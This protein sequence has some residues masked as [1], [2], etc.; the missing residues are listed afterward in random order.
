MR[1]PA[2]FSDTDSLGVA[3][4]WLREQIRDEGARCPC[5]TQMAKVYPRP[6]YTAQAAALI[7][8]FR[9][10]GRDPG[11]WSTLRLP[12]GDY[13][14]LRFWGLIVDMREL[15]EDGGPAGWWQ[16]TDLGEK[17]VRGAVT[18]PRFARIYDNRCLGL[19][20]ESGEVS[21]HDVLG[22]AFDYATLMGAEGKN[23]EGVI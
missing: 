21:I 6:I 22:D 18:I 10:F 5:C 2:L 23:A 3:R 11:K 1:A 7:K 19:D 9:V 4:A 15:R 13:A 12:G 16:I 17:W 8:A 20:H 14:K